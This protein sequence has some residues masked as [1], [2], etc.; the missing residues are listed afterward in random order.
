MN[1][2]IHGKQQHYMER[3]YTKHRVFTIKVYVKFFPQS[4]FHKKNVAA[5]HSAKT[6]LEQP[7]H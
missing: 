6:R 2:R 4:N 5:P 3:M 1:E 7:A